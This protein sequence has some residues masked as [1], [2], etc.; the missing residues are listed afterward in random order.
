MFGRC[1][2][3]GTKICRQPIIPAISCVSSGGRMTSSAPHITNVRLASSEDRR[4]SAFGRVKIRRPKGTID[5]RSRAV[6]NPDSTRLRRT[7]NRS[8][9]AAFLRKNSGTILSSIFEG[10][11]PRASISSRI[12]KYRSRVSIGSS[13]RYVAIMTR[14]LTRDGSFIASSAPHIPPTEEPMTAHFSIP[15]ASRKW[16]K[17]PA[18]SAEVRAS[19]GSLPD[20]PCPHRS[21]AMTR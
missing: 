12:P 17:Y 14:L 18:R 9:M 4:A 10:M 19:A 1:P 21:G 6:E 11:A 16:L 15:S 5:S 7:G 3:F 13:P 20:S 8:S 2:A